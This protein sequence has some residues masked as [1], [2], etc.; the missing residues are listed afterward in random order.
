MTIPA[1]SSARTRSRVSRRWAVAGIEVGQRLVDHVQAR[2]HHEDRRPREELPL[3]AREGR[4]LATQERLDA[5][6]GGDLADA[7]DASRDAEC[8]GSPGRRRARPRPWPRRSAWPGPAAPCPR[9]RARSRSFRSVVARPSTRTTPDSSPGIGVRDQAVDGPDQR[10][11]A[12]S[13]RTGDEDDLTRPRPS[14]TGRGWRARWP[15]GSGRSDPRHRRAGR[16]DRDSHRGSVRARHGRTHAE[17]IR[18]GRSSVR[19]RRRAASPWLSASERWPSESAIS[20]DDPTGT[21]PN[22]RSQTV[23]SSHGRRSVVLGE[24]DDERVARVPAARGPPR[25][26]RA[27]RRT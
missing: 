16:P 15:A 23:R 21:R 22:V 12:A 10:A 4:G 26:R 19:P 6:L 13:R 24:L 11:L 8:P 9:V 3:A 25:G 14:A 5:G 2:S 27:S 17:R 20:S 18:A 1:P 7:L